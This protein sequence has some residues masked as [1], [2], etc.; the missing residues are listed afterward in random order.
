MQTPV[1]PTIPSTAQFDS[2][3][4]DQL[5]KTNHEIVQGSQVVTG[6]FTQGGILS[7]IDGQDQVYP[8]S[9]ITGGM[10]KRTGLTVSYSNDT[11]PS[12]TDIAD[13]LELPKAEGISFVRTF[14][15]NNPT[16]YAINLSGTGW[17]FLTTTSNSSGIFLGE[18]SYT[19]MYNITYTTEDG[20]T[21]I[22]F[23]TGVYDFS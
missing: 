3:Q 23:I 10:L 22:C 14:G 20:W 9:C 13:N 4:V 17:T 12:A 7:T 15:L 6:N 2:I 18:H 21:I 19:V 8:A 11:L 16:G 1:P 5:I